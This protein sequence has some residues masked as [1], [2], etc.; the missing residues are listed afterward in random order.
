MLTMKSMTVSNKSN[1]KTMIKV[2]KNNKQKVEA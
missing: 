2:F 1:P